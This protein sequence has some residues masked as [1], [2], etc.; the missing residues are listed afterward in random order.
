MTNER[1]CK[2]C[3]KPLKPDGDWDGVCSTMCAILSGEKSMGEED[4]EILEQG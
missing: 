4:G 3:D 1:T 2:W